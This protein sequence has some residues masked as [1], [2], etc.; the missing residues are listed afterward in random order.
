[1]PSPLTSKKA[2]KLNGEINVPGDKSI[3]HRALIISSQALGRSE[4]TGLLESDDVIHTS[5]ALKLMG[6]EIEKTRQGSWL[7]EGVGT[8]GL[9]EPD[10][11]LYMGN[12]GTGTRLMMGLVSTHPF[13]SFFNGDESLRKRPMKRV[14]E[15]LQ[16]SGAQILSRKGGLLPLAVIGAASPIPFTYEMN[17]ASAQV[18]SAILLAALNI[19]GRTTVI[20]KEPTRDH[21]ELMMQYFGIH[22]ISEKEKSK[23]I[24]SVTGQ[25][26]LTGKRIV[27]PG[28]P[29]SAAFAVVAALLVP[30]SDVTIK[31][32]CI[33]PL[34]TGLYKT[35]E[36]M[37]ADITY[38]N[39]R[40]L[41]GEKIA[42]LRIKTSSLEGTE[43][44]ASRAP[45][46]I[47]EY[48]ILAIAASC[49]KGKTVMKGLA[50]LKV[51]ESDRLSAMAEGLKASGVKT[52]VS[53]DS[54]IV[55][56]T[57]KPP[58]GGSFISTYMDH[59]IA[60]SFLILGMVAEKQITVDDSSMISTSFPDFTEL[61]NKIGGN[62][63]EHGQHRKIAKK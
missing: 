51:K 36:E 6:V 17:V 2:I 21:T 24:I 20:E 63:I 53:G 13:L 60:M 38:M 59:R 28:D 11:I 10:D 48:P 39:E 45:S 16:K 19:P 41:A 43:V 42:D 5:E 58:A 62:I 26:E 57:G 52:E 40:E 15:P 27:V 4:I 35:L 56:G 37:G 33:N 25:P 31:N 46:M 47:D 23:T 55:Y 7:V 18:K 8:G 34:R 9:T 1:M 30:D 12:S 32:V 50:E 22:I 54:L 14:S 29:S 61:M 44:P 49:A 3:S